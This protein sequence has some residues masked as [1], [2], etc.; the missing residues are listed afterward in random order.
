MTLEVA[1]DTTGI[2]YAFIVAYMAQHGYAPSVREIAHGC[3][4]GLGT[5]MW[6]LTRLEARGRIRR[7]PG[8]ARSIT[9]V[10]SNTK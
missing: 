5:V 2:V 10:K 9:L 6:H 8:V 3:F 4:L 7:E 1:K